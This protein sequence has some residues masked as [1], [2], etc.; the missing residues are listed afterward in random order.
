MPRPDRAPRWVRW[1]YWT[2]LIDRYAYAWM[3][4]HGAWDVVPPGAGVPGGGGAAGV[5]EPGRP[6]GPSGTGAVP[7]PAGPE[8]RA[9]TASAGPDL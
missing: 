9:S 8:P 2:P 1:W 3:W 4:W 6:A 7:V 5:R